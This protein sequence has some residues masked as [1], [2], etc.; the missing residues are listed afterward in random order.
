VEHTRKLREP[1]DFSRALRLD[2][3]YDGEMVRFLE[4]HP[5]I[6]TQLVS[7]QD[8]VLDQVK[9]ANKLAGFL[10]LG[11]SAHTSRAVTEFVIPRDRLP[12][13]KRKRRSFLQAKLPKLIRKWSRQNRTLN[14]TQVKLVVLAYA[15]LSL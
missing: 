13:E 3:F 4:M 14:N 12:A 6:Q 2:H 15:A 7:Y 1:L 11:M 10:G 9:E 5:E 8:V